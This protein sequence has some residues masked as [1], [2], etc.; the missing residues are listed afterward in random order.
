MCNVIQHVVEVAV[1]AFVAVP[2]N[3]PS[4]G[5][6]EPRAPVIVGDCLVRF[7]RSAVE[8]NDELCC[9]TRKVHDV[10]TEWMLPAEACACELA[11]AQA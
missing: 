7:V 4:S 8:F 9:N 11:T 1:D 2:H 10:G 3:A 6:E 5:L